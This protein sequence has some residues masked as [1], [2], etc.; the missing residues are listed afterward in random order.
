M[1]EMTSFNGKT[2]GTPSNEEM[3][4]VEMQNFKSGKQTINSFNTFHD[5]VKVSEQNEFS[6][7]T[8]HPDPREKSD[9]DLNF[10][11][12]LERAMLE[13]NNEDSD[14]NSTLDIPRTLPEPTLEDTSTLANVPSIVLPL[15]NGHLDDLRQPKPSNIF[16][17]LP[18]ETLYRI[19]SFLD[20]V[21]IGRAAQVC[22]RFRTLSYDPL[23][24]R[25]E[26]KLW[27][28]NSSS[29][30]SSPVLLMEQPNNS[31]YSFYVERYQS[32]RRHEREAAKQ[33]FEN[34]RQ[35]MRQNHL[36]NTSVCM[37]WLGCM[38]L[39][40]EWL[41]A[42]CSLLGTVL[43]ALK[44]DQNSSLVNTPWTLI[45]IPVYILVARLLFIP[46]LFD[47]MRLL[48]NYSFTDEFDFE[49]GDIDKAVSCGP[50]IT[51]FLFLL[52]LE[53]APWKTRVLLYPFVSGLFVF[54]ILLS[55]NIN[56]SVNHISHLSMNSTFSN[57]NTSGNFSAP[58]NV[59]YSNES[60]SQVSPP[61]PYWAVFLPLLISVMMIVISPLIIGKYS[62]VLDDSCWLD[63]VMASLYLLVFWLF[64]L[65][66][67]LKLEGPL[68]SWSWYSVM[69]PLWTFEGLLLLTP[70]TIFLLKIVLEYYG[71]YWMDDHSRWPDSS[72]FYLST[73][74]V[75]TIVIVP[76][77]NFEE[78]L[79]EKLEGNSSHSFIT[80][81]SPIFVLQGSISSDEI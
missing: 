74:I 21:S 40:Y 52:P 11:R 48:H 44:L 42:L 38:A 17:R 81:F 80:V 59:P 69:S 77:I 68:N 5:E 37:N 55:L 61:I 35:K 34:Q 66:I 63:R 33:R 16:D 32:L 62:S 22:K 64:V 60:V 6:P 75:I 20:F 29:S 8:C 3:T 14:C 54:L 15:D 1:L 53:K 79:A 13:D 10:E 4:E 45:L 31:S 23:L 26:A 65:F 71:V 12:E 18:Y 24:L 7:Y 46:V 70:L 25:D 67:A 56:L 39:P 43:I 76:L 73:S 19:W 30:L 50:F 2:N 9:L 78:M 72:C 58:F 27:M 57:T 49:D 41:M 51:Y 36:K 47:S 28:K